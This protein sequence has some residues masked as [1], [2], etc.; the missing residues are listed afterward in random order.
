MSRLFLGLDGG[1]SKT[2]AL[3]SDEEGQILGRGDGGPSNFH[4]LGPERAFAV[5]EQTIISAFADAGLHLA[6]IAAAVLGMAGVDRPEEHALCQ[7]WARQFLGGAAVRIVNDAQLV[8]EYPVAGHPNG[9]Q[10]AVISGTG[11]IVY[12]RRA[13]SVDEN[14]S[15]LERCSGWGY[16][17]GDEGSGFWV[18]QEAL[19]AVARA[20]D[21]RSTEGLSLVQPVLQFWGLKQPQQLITYVYGQAAP[22][23]EIARLAKV[24]DELALL[25]DLAAQRI[26]EQAGVELALAFDAVARRLD[27]FTRQPLAVALAGGLFIH[28]QSLRQA[29][30]QAVRQA[31]WLPDPITLVSEPAQGALHLALDLFKKG[32]EA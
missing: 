22:R 14:L 15:A 29:F 21:G 13:G 24:V 27:F 18:G 9:S 25:G 1:G 12:G 11:A 2:L 5:L 16:L 3:L 28:A 17:F 30:L 4:V 10:I 32:K 19:R 20:V 26:I 7:A 8:L 31:G 23:S 6:P